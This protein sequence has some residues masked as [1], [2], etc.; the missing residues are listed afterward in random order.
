M[1]PQRVSLC[2]LAGLLL[3]ACAIPTTPALVP[4]ELRELVERY[5]VADSPT[6]L[7]EHELTFG[8]YTARHIGG[9][10]KT[11]QSDAALLNK[12]TDTS[13]YT[14][15]G[16]FDFESPGMNFH[17]E[18]K[19]ERRHVVQHRRGEFEWGLQNGHFYAGFKDDP[20]VLEASYSY[21]CAL[22]R[23][24][25]TRVSLE[26]DG[27][28]GVVRAAERELIFGSIGDGSE[29][30]ETFWG[31]STGYLFVQ[32]QEPVAAVDLREGRMSVTLLRDLPTSQKNDLAALA[33]AMLF[34]RDMF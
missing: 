21:R 28:S 4:L 34:L 12:Q 32:A 22:Q 31:L 23:S 7:G 2:L 6:Y 25:G 29:N 20:R 13:E 17:A 5:P 3:S 15:T 30:P 11:F 26:F 14:Y 19:K 10:R 16:S 18:C 33:M 1:S 24:T 27:F 9:Y 8:P